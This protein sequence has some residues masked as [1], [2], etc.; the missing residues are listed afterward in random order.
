MICPSR[1]TEK[2]DKYDKEVLGKSW[3]RQS[4]GHQDANRL[5]HELSQNPYKDPQRHLKAGNKGL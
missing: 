4:I 1:Q 5:R 2:E 3:R